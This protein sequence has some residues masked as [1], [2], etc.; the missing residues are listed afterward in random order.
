MPLLFY[1]IENYPSFKRL[2]RENLVML[3]NRRL[4]RKSIVWFLVAALTVGTLVGCGGADDGEDITLV[5]RIPD[6]AKVNELLQWIEAM[7]S[8]ETRL[9]IYLAE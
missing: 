3:I 6:E 2:F 1:V 7:D 4:N 8:I 9:G 5:V